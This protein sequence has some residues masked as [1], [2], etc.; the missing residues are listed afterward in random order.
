MPDL[1]P[2]K[3]FLAKQHADKLGPFAMAMAAMGIILLLGTFIVV[4]VSIP[5]AEPEFIAKKAIYLPQRE[6]EHKMSVSEFQQ[7]AASPIS[8]EK[9]S[10]ETMLSDIPPMPQLPLSEFSPLKS[11]NPYSSGLGLFGNSG[12]MGAMQGLT[13]EPSQISI[14]GIRDTAKR[15]VIAF[16][17]STSVINAMTKAGMKTT[18]MK[19][20]TIKLIKQLNANTL[21]GLIQH[22]R[23]YDVF[24]DFMVPATVSNKESAIKWMESEF[25]TGG[26]PGYNWQ[27]GTP[28][29]IEL[30]LD[31]VFKMQP[32]VVFLVSDA[33]YQ[34]AK[35]ERSYENVPWRE[36]ENKI[37]SLQDQLPVPA[38]I[39][40]I[41]FSVKDDNAK[42]MKSIIRKNK[43][44]YKQY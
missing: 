29:G 32:D 22:S 13:T 38:R 17:I 3:Q 41:G 19:E 44:K 33:S 34:R 28:N 9:L 16:D 30:V 14:L 11:D 1:S 6:L 5:E 10:A 2:T 4:L 27:S 21:F 43:G 26:K 7:A 8:I 12:L 25:R 20:E 36:L 15:F 23:T 18:E 39:H 40:F 31:A 35:G 37:K 24:Q 42:E